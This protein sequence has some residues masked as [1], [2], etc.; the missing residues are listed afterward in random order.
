MVHGGLQLR[1]CNRVDGQHG[2]LPLDQGEH[3]HQHWHQQHVDTMC[4]IDV[5][6][7]DHNPHITTLVAA[8]G[9]GGGEPGR[10]PSSGE[11]TWRCSPAY[12]GDPVRADLFNYHHREISSREAY[13][14]KSSSL[15][16]HCPPK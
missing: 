1:Q 16:G 4:T 2:H 13:L 15:F 14:E 6:M 5:M 7:A 8:R 12:S 9:G 11:H 10:Q 3:Q